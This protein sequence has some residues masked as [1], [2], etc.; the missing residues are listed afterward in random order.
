MRAAARSTIV[1]VA[2]R[3]HGRA[4]ALRAGVGHPARCRRLPGPARRATTSM[5]S[6]FRFPT[7]CTSSGRWRAS[8]LASTCSA[9]SRWRCSPDDVLRLERAAE[10]TRVIVAEGFMYRHEPLTRA[11]VSLVRD[12]AI[13]AVRTMNAGFTYAQSRADDVRLDKALGGGALLDVGCYPVSYACLLVGRDVSARR[14]NGAAH[15]RPAWTRSSP[16][17]CAS[18]AI[19]TATIYAGFRA[20]YSHLARGDRIGGLAAGAEPVQ[21]GPGGDDRAGAF[22]R[23]P[24]DRDRRARR[25]CS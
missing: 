9:R 23:T 12:G 17:S 14:G 10:A 18:P 6:T 3:D 20:A 7:A 5:P 21:A 4:D 19:R 25:N 15:R 1:A 16:G 8:R 11:V 22:R 24:G 13:G 2:S